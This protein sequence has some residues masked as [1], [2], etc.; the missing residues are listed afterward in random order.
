RTLA[1]RGASS[2]TCGAAASATGA[3]DGSATGAL[4]GNSGSGKLSTDCGAVAAGS[5]TGETSTGSTTGDGSALEISLAAADSGLVSSTAGALVTSTF[6]GGTCEITS[7]RLVRRRITF[8]PTRRSTICSR[9]L[10]SPRV[11]SADVTTLS[12]TTFSVPTT[13]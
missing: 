11:A 8:V 4:A 2:T 1:P 13:T 9:A 12:A 6:A 10:I 3:G 5:S 7:S